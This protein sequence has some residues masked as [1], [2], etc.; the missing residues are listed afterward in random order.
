MVK[1]K[2]IRNGTNE[3]LV[4]NTMCSNQRVAHAFFAV[5]AVIQSPRPQPTA[6]VR[7]QRDLRQ[8]ALNEVI[9]RI[10]SAELVATHAFSNRGRASS[11]GCRRGNARRYGRRMRT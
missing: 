6:T 5:P 7:L 4:C 3:H 9:G 11:G 1:L 10:G 8:Q 2:T